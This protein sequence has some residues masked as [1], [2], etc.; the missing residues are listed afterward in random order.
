MTEF[1]LPTIPAYEALYAYLPTEG[2]LSESKDTYHIDH[3]LFRLSEWVARRS[4]HDTIVVCETILSTLYRMTH[5]S[6]LRPVYTHKELWI[7]DTGSIL[8]IPTKF[9]QDTPNTSANSANS[10]NST[11]KT[12]MYSLSRYIQKTLLKSRHN[13]N[14][15]QI[16]QVR[17]MLGMIPI[18]HTLERMTYNAPYGVVY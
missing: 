6:P 4:L 17:D 16:K 8:W 11:K 14:P 9:R 12:W 15:T 13:P 3:R 10:A 2:T 7:V 1:N 5:A 18:T